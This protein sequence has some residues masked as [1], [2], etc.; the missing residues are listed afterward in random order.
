ME[1]IN[2]MVSLSKTSFCNFPINALSRS[3]MTIMTFWRFWA[4][5]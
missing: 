5:C 2:R 1:H 3:P 4:T